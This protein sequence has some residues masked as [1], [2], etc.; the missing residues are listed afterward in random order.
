MTVLMWV[1]GIPLIL[2]V[3]VCCYISCIIG[4]HRITR[5][6]ALQL[7][8]LSLLPGINW[9][10]VGAAIVATLICDETK[11]WLNKPVRAAPEVDKTVTP[12]PRHKVDEVA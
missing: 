12:E 6:D 1:Y 5:K 2:S 8:V 11:D 10:I 7:M 4:L 9:I 3:I